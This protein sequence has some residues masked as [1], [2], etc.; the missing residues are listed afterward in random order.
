M[1]VRTL[2]LLRHAKSDYPAGV[3]DR[4]R[5]LAPRGERDADAAGAWLEAAYPRIDE[6]V[7]SPALRAQQTW[8]RVA[9]RVHS[10]TAREDPRIYDDWGSA[11]H[12][13]M[14][15]LSDDASIAMLVGHN[16]GIEEF[17]LSLAERG[18]QSAR[19]RLMAKY[20]TSG[21][22]VLLVP[23]SW[24]RPGAVELAA[25]AVPRG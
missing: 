8:A 12:D 18:D 25:F 17:A 6:V 1:I 16:P 20:P 19:A 5:P 23:G 11:L 13:V 15:G 24:A 4:D 21:I 22:A 7:V 2:L 14:A 3:A 10:S 9:S